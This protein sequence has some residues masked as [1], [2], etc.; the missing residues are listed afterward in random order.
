[1]KEQ[2]QIKAIAE[3]DGFD[4]TNGVMEYD[5]AKFPYTVFVKFD[6][7]YNS[8]DDRFKYLTSRDAIV[9]VI[10]KL[11]KELWCKFIYDLTLDVLKLCP[12][13]GSDE[14]C[15]MANEL[16]CIVIIKATPFQLCEALLRATGKW[17]ATN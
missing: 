4:I 13:V 5:G 3:L 10:E 7:T 6:E 14:A 8:T 16:D 2:D 12:I 11:P 15:F 9:R 17:K 1:M